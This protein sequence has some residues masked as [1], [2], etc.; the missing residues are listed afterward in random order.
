MDSTAAAGGVQKNPGEIPTSSPQQRE[1]KIRRILSKKRSHSSSPIE[2]ATDLPADGVHAAVQHMPTAFPPAVWA[3][4]Y[5]VFTFVYHKQQGS[6]RSFFGSQG[7]SSSSPVAEWSLYNSR[8]TVPWEGGWQA[9]AFERAGYRAYW[10]W[11]TSC[12]DSRKERARII[13]YILQPSDCWSRLQ[14]EIK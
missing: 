8:G 7:H 9:I 4:S 3:C 6:K 5:T 1:W 10:W 12:A 2:K 14:R 13:S 11:R